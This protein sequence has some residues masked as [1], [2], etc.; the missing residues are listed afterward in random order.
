MDRYSIKV[1]KNL[2]N[3]VGSAQHVIRV[4]SEY[5]PFLYIREKGLKNIQMQT[6]T[7]DR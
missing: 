7:V 3:A 4:V 2:S 5:L 6:K 1:N